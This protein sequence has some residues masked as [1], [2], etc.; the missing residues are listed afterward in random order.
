MVERRLI[1][2]EGTVQGVGFRPY[3]HRLASANQ[4]R[5]VVRNG[6][7]GVLIDIEGDS[8][9]VDAFCEALTHAPPPL[10]DISRVRVERA[11]PFAYQAF[12]IAESDLVAVESAGP[13]VPPDV[14]TCDACVAE[15][16]DPSSR[17]YQHPFIT[18]TDCG[19][20]F[21]IVRDTPY[22]RAR[23]TMAD[24][25]MCRD[26]RQEYYDP[27]DRR[28]HAEAIACWSCGPTLRATPSAAGDHRCSGRDAVRAGVET[29]RS[30][31]I[32][33][34]KALGG[35]HLACDATNALAVALLRARKHRIA[36]PMAVMVR[37]AA[38]ADVRCFVSPT[39]R[40]LLESPARPI[41]L[42]ARRPGDGV[43]DTVAP[44]QRMLGV[45]L[46]STPLHHL[47]VRALDRPLVMTS[48][49]RRGEPVI[50]DETSAF[51]ALGRV[52]DL[53]LVHDRAI[54]ARCDDSVVHVVTGAAQALRRSRGYASRCVAL[55]ELT[56]RPVLALGGHLKN[57][58]CLA[59][60]S[61]ALLSAH[62]GDLDAVES[63][64]ALRGA[65][66]WTVRT[67]RATPTVIA[68]DLHP[69][70]VSTRVAHELVTELG[71]RNRVAVQH[72]HAHVAACVAE[73]G[74]TGPV[75][76]VAFDGAGLG[77]DGAI[78]GGEF[79][80]ADGASFERSGH[81]AY[82]PLPGGDATA[83]RPWRSA[84]AHLEMAGGMMRP[85]AVEP[86]EWRALGQLLSRPEQLPRTSS[87]GRLFDAVASVLGLCHVSRFEGEAA[88][89]VEAVADP[90]ADRGYPARIVDGGPWTID[91]GAIVRAVADDRRRGLPVP[92]IAG[93][94]H[95]AL[96][97]VIVAGCERIRE[98]TGV[99]VVALGGG[100][101]VN[102]LLLALSTAKLADRGFRV[103]VPR[104]VPCNDGGLSLGQ[105]YVAARALEE[106]TVCA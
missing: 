69:E 25:A 103:L 4:L 68:H 47:L 92:E 59:T 86:A 45:M 18:C 22:D 2:V 73:H 99:S 66:A 34:L 49:N 88:M 60:G 42:M 71:I 55:A 90:L 23:T 64:E 102:A 7:A 52:A 89:A 46:P 1:A 32:V 54:A 16:F 81:M 14:A 36:K 62:V 84:R 104:E 72:H 78:W 31:G 53:F 27:A 61:Q 106:D 29:L 35:F 50:T 63:R 11:A 105:A 24:F 41:V 48:G 39:E 67:A 87:V 94:F 75:I 97:D 9:G 82:V 96:G 5:G 15:L 95:R 3:V 12:R 65:V 13:L 58:V 93:A 91:S 19:P 40:L 98:R 26:C 33:A 100:V 76:G 37:D 6:G 30:G 38:A 20:R 70:Y 56:T 74:E 10:A 44:A 17:R 57:T 43:T 21:T 83:L 80:L 101:F 77:S 79:L 8:A 51:V 28:F 85:D